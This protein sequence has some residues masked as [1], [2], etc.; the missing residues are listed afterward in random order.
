MLSYCLASKKIQKT[1]LRVLKSRH[2]KTMILLKK[3]T[4]LMELKI[5]YSEILG[6]F[7]SLKKKKKVI[8]NHH[9]LFIDVISKI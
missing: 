5:S 6:I 9:E 8:M 1:N 7:L 3:K 2:G 4:I